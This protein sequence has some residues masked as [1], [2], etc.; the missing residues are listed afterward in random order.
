MCIYTASTVT[1]QPTVQ[2]RHVDKIV[3]TLLYLI[4]T[5]DLTYYVVVLTKSSTEED[6]ANKIKN[7]LVIFN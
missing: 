7:C 1:N 2:K 5:N 3:D 4:K 6:N